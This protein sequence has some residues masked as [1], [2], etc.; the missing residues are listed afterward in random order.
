MSVQALSRLRLRVASLALWHG[1]D[2]KDMQLRSLELEEDRPFHGG[3]VGR[4][5]RR[6]GNWVGHVVKQNGFKVCLKEMQEGRH[7]THRG[8]LFAI[9]VCTSPFPPP[10]PRSRSFPALLRQPPGRSCFDAGGFS[11]AETGD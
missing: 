3:Q 11:Q 10:P 7:N 6:G 9:A 4:G 5:R 8:V 2:M 1:C